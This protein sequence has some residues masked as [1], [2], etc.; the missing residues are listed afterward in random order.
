MTPRMAAGADLPSATGRR[1][2]R[3][4][5]I[6]QFPWITRGGSIFSALKAFITGETRQQPEP[7]T[8]YS[9]AALRATIF[10]MPGRGR[11]QR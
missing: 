1:A 10:S 7:E 6:S 9:H 5:I 2:R 11:C 4:Q 8:I 3:Y